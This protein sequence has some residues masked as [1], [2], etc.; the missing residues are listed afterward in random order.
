[1]NYL[2]FVYYDNEIKNSGEKTNQL[3]AQ[4]SNVMTSKEIK[5][6]Y[7][8]LHAIFHFASDLSLSEMGE[9]MDLISDDMDCFEF[10]LTQKTK[11][12]YSNFP[13]DNFNHLLT[14]RK[15]TK[16]QTPKKFEFKTPQNEEKGFAKIAQAIWGVQLP[17]VCTMSLDE[18]LDKV[19]EQGLES[20]TKEEKQKLDEY[21]KSI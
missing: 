9:L 18:L 10:F 4:I 2:L 5:F 11:H 15:S 12:N 19:S 8:D 3:G 1:M 21:S 20:L 17:E 13:E 7:G 16:K 14:L 6:M